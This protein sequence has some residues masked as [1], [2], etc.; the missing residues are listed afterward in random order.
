MRSDRMKTLGLTRIGVFEYSPE[1]VFDA[2]EYEVASWGN[3][4][5]GERYL[6]LSR[7]SRK[8]AIGP[9]GYAPPCGIIND[10]FHNFE[11]IVTK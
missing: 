9:V 5:R 11:L 2:F 4:N 6:G 10:T 7:F 8:D 1:S 3:A